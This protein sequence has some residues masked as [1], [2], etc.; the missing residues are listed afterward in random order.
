MSGINTLSDI[1]VC[2]HEG[3]FLPQN[4]YPRD[5]FNKFHYDIVN[6]K[7]MNHKGEK[8]NEVIQYI[9]FMKIVKIEELLHK[10][11]SNALE[12]FTS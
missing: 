10:K 1:L 11:I 6:N 3:C 7:K 5:E 2:Q 4:I 12:G 8:F 9:N